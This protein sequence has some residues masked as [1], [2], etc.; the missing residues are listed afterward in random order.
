MQG[1]GFRLPLMILL[2]WSIF[3]TLRAEN[4]SLIFSTLEVFAVCF[5]AWAYDMV[6][7]MGLVDGL[8]L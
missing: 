1:F 6:N 7:F 2:I 8:L 4:A 5:E 3:F